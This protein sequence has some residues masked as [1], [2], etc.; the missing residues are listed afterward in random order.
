MK[1]D[2]THFLQQLN[3]HCNT[4]IRVSN[5]AN[6]S[7][8]S[9]FGRRHPSTNSPPQKRVKIAHEDLDRDYNPLNLS[10]RF[11][12][13][14]VQQQS[15]LLKTPKKAIMASSP[16]T[17]NT[18]IPHYSLEPISLKIKKLQSDLSSAATGQCWG[19][20]KQKVLDCKHDIDALATMVKELDVDGVA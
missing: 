15:S 17:A 6:M 4:S 14:E 16:P 13:L 5:Q 19:P 20:G 9:S 10:S 3:F 1:T 8:S 12:N 7:K 11:L 2:I 18:Y